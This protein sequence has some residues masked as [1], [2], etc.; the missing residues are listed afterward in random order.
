[1]PMPKV[2]LFAAAAAVLLLTACAADGYRSDADEPTVSYRY[3]DRDEYNEVAERA[4]DYCDD[5]YDRDAYLIDE[6]TEGGD[7]EATFACR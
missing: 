4:D 6:D 7:Y 3:D 2:T 5:A 1:M